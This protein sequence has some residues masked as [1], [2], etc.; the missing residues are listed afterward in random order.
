MIDRVFA[1]IGAFAFA[2]FPQFYSQYLHEL[3]GH[4]KELVYQ[5]NQL[6][7]TMQI[8][9]KTL[10]EL[11]AKFLQSTDSDVSK[12]GEFLNSMVSRLETLNASQV[13]LEEASVFTKPFLF[14]RETDVGIAVQTYKTFQFGFTF[15]WEGLIYALIGLIVGYTL[16]RGVILIFKGIGSL[17][18]RKPD[19]TKESG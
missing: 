1:L 2:Q 3:D 6:K 7:Q 10:Q 18:R 16:F 11:I 15:T 13:H 19:S 5:V 17:F 4:V 14:I 9:G 8:S 12:Q